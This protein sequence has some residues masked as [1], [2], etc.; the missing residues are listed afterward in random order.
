MC[1]SF[2]D[3]SVFVNESPVYATPKRSPREE[4]KKHCHGIIQHEKLNTSKRI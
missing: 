1:M 2:G 4:K 3:G